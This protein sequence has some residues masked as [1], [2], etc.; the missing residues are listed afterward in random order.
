M[1]LKKSF[2]IS[3]RTVLFSNGH[4]YVN[5]RFVYELC[6]FFSVVNSNPF[7]IEE[8]FLGQNDTTWLEAIRTYD[9][10]YSGARIYS[11]I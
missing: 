8:R 1:S 4:F 5:T 11:D 2:I 6:D 7:Q 3:E 9:N 10:A